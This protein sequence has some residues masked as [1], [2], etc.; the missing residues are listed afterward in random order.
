MMIKT[1]LGD[2]TKITDV[3]AIVNAANESL[4]GGGGVDG[5]IHYAAGPELLEECRT[6]GGCRIGEAKMTNGYHLPCKY[7]IH[8]VGPRWHGGSRGEADA[9]ASCYK[10]SLKV[11]MDNGIRTIAFP[12]ISTGVFG[13]PVQEAAGVAVR[14]VREF[15]EECPDAFDLVEWVL[16]DK[17][18]LLVYENAASNNG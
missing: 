12:S 9:L 13:Y 15:L 7:V 6:L 5:A 8:T 17:R 2:I 18:T 3:D 1:I 10:N 14:A 11:A 16:F 4:L